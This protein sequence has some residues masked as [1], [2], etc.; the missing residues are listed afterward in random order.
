MV[1]KLVKVIII[2]ALMAGLAFA[3]AGLVSTLLSTVGL[4]LSDTIIATYC[5]ALGGYLVGTLQKKGVKG[6][7]ITPRI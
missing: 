1:K 6:S 4:Q 3:L 2:P 5:G 7:D